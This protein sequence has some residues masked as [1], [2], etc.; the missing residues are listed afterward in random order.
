MSNSYRDK[1]KTIGTPRRMGQSE[2]KVEKA[3]DATVITTAH[4]DGRQDATVRPA[5]VRKGARVHNTGKKKGELA[6]VTPLSRKERK[7]RYGEQ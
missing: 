2:H 5:T 7:A 6:E 1:L 3:D 4:W